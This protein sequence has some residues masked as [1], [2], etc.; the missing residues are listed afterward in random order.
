[1]KRFLFPLGLIA[2]AAVMIIIFV[3]GNK[4]QAPETKSET[5]LGS[6]HAELARDHIPP[7][8]PRPTYNSNPPSTGPHYYNQDCPAKWG[9]INPQPVQPD[10]CYIHNLE[11]GGI[12]ITYR[13]DLPADQIDK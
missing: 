7:G 1:M 9:T 13:P 12:W 4:A 11:H 2:I 3:L 10:E 8:S 5:K 6:K